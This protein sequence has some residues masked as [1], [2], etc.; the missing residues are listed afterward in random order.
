MMRFGSGQ[1][2]NRQWRIQFKGPPGKV[3]AVT[4]QIR[5]GAVSEI[6][7]AIPFGTREMI[8]ERTERSGANPKVPI[9]ELGTG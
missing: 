1:G 9:Q 7:P 8:I 4:A 6:P 2:L 3:I 5:H